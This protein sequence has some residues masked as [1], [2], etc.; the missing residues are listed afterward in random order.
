MEIIRSRG[1]HEGKKPDIIICAAGTPEMLRKIMELTRWAR[2]HENAEYRIIFQEEE[3]AEKRLGVQTDAVTLQEQRK[4][5]NRKRLER[6]LSANF[7]ED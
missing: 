7:I 1:D 4:Q 2:K 3:Q 6:I 5:E